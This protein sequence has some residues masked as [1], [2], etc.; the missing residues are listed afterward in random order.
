MGENLKIGFIQLNPKFGE[1]ENNVEKAIS[2]IENANADLIVLPELFNTGYLFLNFKEALELAEKVPDGYTTKKLI[3]IAKKTR[4]FIVAGIAELYENK[5]YNSAVIVGP[6][7]YIGTY[8]KAHLFY[9]EKE[10][11]T[12]GN[13][14]FKVFDIGEAKIGVIICFDWCFPEAARI[15]ALKGAD[16]ICHPANLVLPYA[17]KVM[18]ARSIENRVYTI[19]ANRIGTESR[20]GMTL[21]FTG[22]SQITSPKM[23]L[24][25]Q[26]SKDKEEVDVINVDISLARNKWITKLNHV[27]KDRR[28]DLY[29]ELIK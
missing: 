25:V 24:L 12:P 17:Q 8:R 2:Y 16:I 14:G 27:F 6:N 10:I 20:G 1:I 5:V 7:G 18:L 23:E 26:A 3:D 15:L 21:N 11:F 29:A 13:T 28:I 9:K 22:M 19:T 4:T